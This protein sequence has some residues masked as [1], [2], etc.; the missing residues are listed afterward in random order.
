[1]SLKIAETKDFSEG[2]KTQIKEEC[3]EAL[4]LIEIKA[5][6]DPHDVVHEVRKAFKKIRG[7]LRL[8]RDH[9]D[10][11]TE[12]NTFFRDEGRRVSALRDATS[13]IEALDGIYDQYDDQLY[14]K[15]FGKFRDYLVSRQAQMASDQLDQK[16]ILKLIGKNLSEKCGQIDHWPIAIQSFE[17]LSPSV[18][19]VYKR[20]L[21]GYQR[22]DEGGSTEDFHEWR[23]RVKYLRYQLDLLNLIWPNFLDCWEDELHELTNY[24]GDDHDLYN[25]HELVDE[26]TDQFAD[27]ESAQLLKSLI[28]SKRSELQANALQ[29]GKRLYALKPKHFTSLLEA[30]WESFCAAEQQK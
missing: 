17:D 25:L 19:R 6:S 27:P 10:F 7:T 11:Y 26:N 28:H 15:T 24:L 9:I 23:K 13:V 12:E 30:S 21:K 16:G 22:A 5:E 8:I 18:I 20:G 14:K 29:L 1:M 3:S 2:L 4:K